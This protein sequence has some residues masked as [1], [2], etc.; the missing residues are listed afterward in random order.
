[1]A[2]TLWHVMP[3]EV[4]ND[5]AVVWVRRWIGG[6]PFLATWSLSSQ[7]FTHQSGLVLPWYE[8]WRWKHVV[9]P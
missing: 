8:V 3:V 7:T 9:E 6:A 2:R 1:M 4:P 5:G